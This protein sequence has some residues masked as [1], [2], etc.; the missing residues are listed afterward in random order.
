MIFDSL[1]NLSEYDIVT[2]EI[3]EFIKSLNV[4]TPCGRYELSDK[5]YANV[6]DYSTRSEL[7]CPL[8]SHRKFI[9][10]Q[11]VIYGNERIDFINIDGLKVLEGYDH[12]KDIMFYKKPKTE[13]GSIYLNGTNFAIFYPDD[14]HAPQIT[15]LSPMDNVKKVVIK[16]PVE[17]Q[18]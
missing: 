17:W 13:L 15:T 1:E 7:E 12:I 14:A 3:I 11:I 2:A 16:V 5:I 9:D 18:L 8:E 6:E 4:N 10:I